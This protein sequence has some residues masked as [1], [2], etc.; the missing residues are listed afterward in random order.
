MP[1]LWPQA[2]VRDLIEDE[3]QAAVLNAAG[4]SQS[5]LLPGSPSLASPQRPSGDNG[6]ANLAKLERMC[7][8][9]ILWHRGII[10]EAMFAAECDDLRPE[11][12]P[13]EIKVW[14]VRMLANPPPPPKLLAAQTPHSTASPSLIQPAWRTCGTA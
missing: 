4:R 6:P 11:K 5:G 1:A 12:L 9:V 14:G 8:A 7:I 13:R 3:G 2:F 10:E